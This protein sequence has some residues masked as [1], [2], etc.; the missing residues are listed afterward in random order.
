MDLH[1]FKALGGTVQLYL[2][3]RLQCSSNSERGIK[4]IKDSLAWSSLYIC[5]MKS[6]KTC[7]AALLSACVR[8][9]SKAKTTC[10]YSH[11][12]SWWKA[13]WN[14]RTIRVIPKEICSNCKMQHFALVDAHLLTDVKGWKEAMSSSV[15]P[16]G[17]FICL[18]CLIASAFSLQSVPWKRM[19]S[20]EWHAG[21]YAKQLISVTLVLCS[22]WRC[23]FP[24]WS[25]RVCKGQVNS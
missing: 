6:G 10:L 3:W 1:L 14:E 8:R 20:V 9:Y 24:L 25:W 12:S 22:L 17:A 23:Q 16:G 4:C 5:T 18:S 7:S 19:A 2:L 21:E 11:A 13:L 15:K